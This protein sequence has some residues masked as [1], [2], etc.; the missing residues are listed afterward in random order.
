MSYGERAAMSDEPANSACPPKAGPRE[1][2]DERVKS[3]IRQTTVA[4]AALGVV[5]SPIPLAD[6]ILLV[7]M[8]GVMTVRISRARGKVL[9]AVP[10]RPIGKA[11]LA[12]LAARAA[13]NVSFAFVPGVAAVANALSAAALTKLVGDYADAA[14]REGAAPPSPFASW[15]KARTAAPATAG[16]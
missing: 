3:V 2:E 10:W 12:G 11:V 9:R 6:E 13:A 14:V 5:L 15:R 16:G 8:Y 4:S 1:H 7:P